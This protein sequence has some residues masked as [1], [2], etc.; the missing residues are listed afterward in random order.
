MA[1]GADNRVTVRIMGEDYVLKG[2]ASPEQV[3]KVGRHVDTVM[4]EIRQANPSLSTTQVAILAAVNLAADLFRLKEDYE[5]L[6]ALLQ[7]E[8]A[9]TTRSEKP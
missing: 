8:E 7:D 4:N 3:Q 6:L 2:K 9:Q 5:E 1:T